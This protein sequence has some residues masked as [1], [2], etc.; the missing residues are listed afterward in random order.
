MEGHRFFDL[1]RYGT[2][3]PILNAYIAHEIKSGY[4]LLKDA[5]YASPKNDYFPIPQAE[6][7]LSHGVLKQNP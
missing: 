5:V 6:I 7:D 1:V 4:S 2:A 3:A